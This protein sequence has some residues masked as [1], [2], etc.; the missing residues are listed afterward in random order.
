MLVN[1]LAGHVQVDAAAEAQR[2]LSDFGVAA[3]VRAPAPGDLL[4]ELKAAVDAAPDLVVTLAGDGTAR[5]AASL[6][7]PDGP[8]LAP[9]AGGTMN[10]LPHALYG[11]RDWKTVLAAILA[12]GVETPVSGG[13]A[14]GRRFYVA[15]I[16][17]APAIW[18]EAR[19][20]ARQRQL[21]LALRKARNAWR[22]A[23][24]HRVA[25][26]L[27]HHARRKSLA[28]TL[29]CPLVSRAMDVNARALEAAALDP[30]GVA[31]VLRLG[32]RMALS[33]LAGDWRDD[34]AVDVTRCRAG[35][36]WTNGRH[37]HAILDGEP[38]RL[39]K[40]IEVRFSPRAFRAL[41]PSGE[42]GV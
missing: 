30:Q 29:I 42:L 3:R 22:R 12:D 39:H 38:F 34:P 37:L 33:Q 36:A 35:H 13:E 18:A 6:C 21:V 7:G 1:P 26:Q 41:V 25:Y 10:M 2:I 19:E 23:F 17:G 24:S 9:L 15:A 20:A 4:H 31:D 8:V 32:A 11:Q 27:D 14:D 16:L 40:R 5:A 28:L